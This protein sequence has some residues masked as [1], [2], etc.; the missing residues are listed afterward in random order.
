MKLSEAI[1]LGST[2]LTPKAGGQAFRRE[3]GRLCSRHG[4]YRQGMHFWSCHP[5]VS[6]ER[7]AD[8]GHGRCLGKLGAARHR[9]P[10][11]LLAFLGAARDAN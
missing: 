5:P 11:P 8:P 9:S 2:V 3:S 7:P 10:L 6:R 1:L 4:R